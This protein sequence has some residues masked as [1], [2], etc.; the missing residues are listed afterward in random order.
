MGIQHEVIKYQL[1]IQSLGID[2]KSEALDIIPV[3]I[4]RLGSSFESPSVYEPLKTVILQ[5]LLSNRKNNRKRAGICIG[6]ENSLHPLIIQSYLIVNQ[7]N[8][9]PS[10]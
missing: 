10:I 6:M 8:R 5:Q 4:Q 3:A 9:S 2:V 1:F 7:T